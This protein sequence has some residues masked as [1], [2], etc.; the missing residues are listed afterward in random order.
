MKIINFISI[1]FVSVLLLP[2]I[3]NPKCYPIIISTTYCDW[4]KTK[5]EL[6]EKLK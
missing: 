1:L 6:K 5:D 3:Y 4:K 2:F